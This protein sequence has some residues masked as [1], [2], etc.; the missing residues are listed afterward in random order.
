MNE[1]DILYH[2]E[3]QLLG[4][5][6]SK[7]RGKYLTIRLWDVEDD[8]LINFR[9][10]DGKDSKSMPVLNATITRGDI[11]ETVEEENYGKMASGLY[12]AGFFIT[13]PVLAAIG[14]DKQFRKWVQK[15]PSAISEEYS[16]WID[17]EGRCEAA[18][19]RRSSEAGTSYKPDYACIPLTHQEHQQQHNHGETSLKPRE[20]FEKARNKYVIEWA[21]TTLLATLGDYIGFREVPPDVLRAWCQEHDLMNYLPNSYR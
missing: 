9:G 14:S 7:A 13:P 2:G 17:G 20:W 12:A 8:P 10:I 15:Q 18:H 6:E 3:I 11:V 1:L 4:W 19:V 21:K 5:G 16:E